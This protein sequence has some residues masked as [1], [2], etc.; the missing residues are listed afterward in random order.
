MYIMFHFITLI[1]IIIIIII[2]GTTNG[3][4][5]VYPKYQVISYGFWGAAWISSVRYVHTGIVVEE[6]STVIF[7]T[8]FNL[9]LINHDTFDAV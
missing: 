2:T 5:L 3:Y 8:I 7:Q 9:S 1:I 4:R 6:K